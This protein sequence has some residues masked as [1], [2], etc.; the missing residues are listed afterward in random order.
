[1]LPAFTDDGRPSPV[2]GALGA[3][4][5]LIFIGAVVLTFQPVS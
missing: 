1:M 3:L 5:L 2:V 4:A